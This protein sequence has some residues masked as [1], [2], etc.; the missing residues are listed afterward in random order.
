MSDLS[1]ENED[2]LRARTW[3]LYR[4]KH[5]VTT[6]ADLYWQLDVQRATPDEQHGALVSFVALPAWRAAPAELKAEVEAVLRA[7]ER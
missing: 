7:L 5:L 1:I 6:L 2:W 4:G 3:D